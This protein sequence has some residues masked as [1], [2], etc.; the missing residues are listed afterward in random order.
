MD[1]IELS[2]FKFG[3]LSGNRH[4]AFRVLPAEVYNLTI[5]KP[6]GPFQT[7][8]FED[9]RKLL[10]ATAAIEMEFWFD[11]HAATQFVSGALFRWVI[12]LRLENV[13]GVFEG[14]LRTHRVGIDPTVF[15]ALAWLPAAIVV[16]SVVSL[17]LGAKAIAAAAGVYRRTKRRWNTIPKERLEDSYRRLELHIR[18]ITEWDDIPLTVKFDFFGTWYGVEITGEAF[19][20]I[21]QL[22]GLFED[23]TGMPISDMSRSL[24]GVGIII[25]CVN[26]TK[27]FEYWKKFYTLILTLQG[28]GLSFLLR[29]C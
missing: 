28:Y 11:N 8:S 17:S 20:I 14:E 16:V 29:P 19:V 4:D 10:I 13:A 24:L 5:D 12:T 7:L 2:L 1:P 3:N 23:S 15:R 26:M 21:S 6:L 25:L 9:A 22:M 18:P 27:Y